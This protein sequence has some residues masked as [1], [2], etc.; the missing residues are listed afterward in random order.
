VIK[1]DVFKEIEKILKLGKHNFYLSSYIEKVNVYEI[2]KRFG[3]E[4]FELPE[5]GTYDL[6]L[7]VDENGGKV[8]WKRR[9]IE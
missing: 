4:I 5:E 3:R 2:K 1:G 9:H 8:F 6:V 7:S